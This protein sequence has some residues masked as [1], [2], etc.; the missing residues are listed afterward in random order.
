MRVKGRR[1]RFVAVSVAAIVLVVAFGPHRDLFGYTTTGYVW[2]AEPGPGGP[3]RVVWHPVTSPG[4][5]NFV[6]PITYSLGPGAPAG[7]E[8]EVQA[9]FDRW[10]QIAGPASIRYRKVTSGGDVMVNFGTNPAGVPGQ[11]TLNLSGGAFTIDTG[12]VV[13]LDRF[14]LDIP[15]LN[16]VASDPL[17]EYDLYTVTI[18]EVG[19]DL[20]LEHRRNGCSS[21]TAQNHARGIPCPEWVPD[22]TVPLEG[23]PIDTL[24]YNNP[25]RI[26]L[27]DDIRGL[28]TLYSQPNGEMELLKSSF[29]KFT[30]L[31]SYEYR[32]NNK[33]I[34][35]SDYFLNRVEIPL[36]GVAAVNIETPTGFVL[37]PDTDE[38]RIV[39]EADTGNTGIAPGGS[40]I[41][42]FNFQHNLAPQF[43]ASLVT[44]GFS[45]P[46]L[47]VIGSGSSGDF[48]DPGN[49][50]VVD[51]FHSGIPP[52][53]GIPFD[54]T[55]VLSTSDAFTPQ[56]F[57]ADVP[58]LSQWG[59]M[60]LSG[61]LMGSLVYTL[62]RRRR[63]LPA[64]S[65]T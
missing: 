46:N 29:D 24:V 34:S 2:Q 17:D 55:T 11:I 56:F 59:L 19:H 42:G 50:S 14:L 43:G 37:S 60:I 38:N 26:L 64:R 45:L 13:R 30:K 25:R 31:F 15:P 4:K 12:L 61:L 41:L 58:T 9:A 5:V 35:G 20:G 23:F 8:A 63:S 39:W 16:S 28:R 49:P 21:L 7:A 40:S 54:P 57:S 22:P 44:S 32:A 47:A 6:S 27:A 52:V 1:E 18:H 51:L 62:V 36:S 10:N 33:S 65:G 3:Q 48:D 53:G